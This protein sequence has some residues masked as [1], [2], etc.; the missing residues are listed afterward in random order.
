MKK[1]LVLLLAFLLL[2]SA[3]VPFTALAEEAEDETAFLQ[4]SWIPE[5]VQEN[6][7]VLALGALVVLM[8][9]AFVVKNKVIY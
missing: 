8:I 3:L 4:Q 6:A 7:M 2:M 1:T 9:I 5:F